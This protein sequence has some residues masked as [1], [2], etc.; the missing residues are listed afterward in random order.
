M[1]NTIS[2]KADQLYLIIDEAHRGAKTGNNAAVATTIMQKFIKGSAEDGLEKTPP[3]IIG[4][5]ATIERFNALVAGTNFSTYKV[6]VTDND[7]KNSGLLK[8][9]IILVYPKENVISVDMSI[10]EAAADEYKNK[11]EHWQRYCRTQQIKP[12]NPIFVVQVTNGKGD[13]ISETNLDECLKRISERTGFKFD[14]GEVVHTFGE[15]QSELLINNLR[16]V[17]EEPS[18]IAKN[19]KIKVVFF[20]ENLS[21]GWDCPQAEVM[22]SFRRAKDST[23]IAQLLGRMIRTPLQQKITS[24]ETLNEVRLY[25]P[26]FD[27]ETA[28]TIVDELKNIEGGDIPAYITSEAEDNRNS[29]TLTVNVPAAENIPAAP[30]AENISAPENLPQDFLEKIFNEKPERKSEENIPADFTKVESSFNRKEVLDAINKMGVLTYEVRKQRINDYLK[31]LL[32]LA[33]FFNRAGI[34]FDAAEI[35]KDEI[36]EIIHNYIEKLKFD[37]EYENLNQKIKQFKLF[38]QVFDS[39]GNPVEKAVSKNL[40]VTTDSDIEHQFNQAESKLKKEGIAYA[41]VAKFCKSYEDEEYNNLMI[42]VIIFTSNGAC[43]QQLENFAQKRFYELN[44]KYRRAVVN[45]S[46]KFKNEY[47]TIISES[48]SVTEHFLTLPE[49]IEIPNDKDGKNYSDHLFINE[50]TGTACIKLNGWEE[51]VLREEQQRKDFVCWI[52]N[53]QR[54][55][56]AMCIPYR[57]ENNELNRMFPDFLIVRKINGKYIVDILEP[58]DASRRD[59]IDKAQGFAEYSAKNNGVDRIELIREISRAGNRF[60]SRLDFSKSEISA[61][62]SRAVSNSEL[63]NIFINYGTNENL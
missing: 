61:E 10:L 52:R 50:K 37:G 9:K 30:V 53:P 55:N 51:G 59:N 40:F 38:A 42:D 32:K 17:Y 58:H 18:H 60:F 8:E 2:E 33:N 43:L 41:Y 21:T 24:D 39:L 4:M 63:D 27:K 13:I 22:M 5:S 28:N 23:Y 62:V 36:V 15:K 20:K 29:V 54:K 57:Q 47:D 35:V 19:D 12:F 56:W 6:E 25:L 45:L 44:K 11:F 46:E 1:N 16:V 3:V 49:T 34:F 26:H 31:S 7:V 14:T 48:D